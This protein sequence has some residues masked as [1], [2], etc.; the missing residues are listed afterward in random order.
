MWYYRKKDILKR[1]GKD[2]KYIRALDRAIR[3]GRVIREENNWVVRWATRE[4]YE[5]DSIVELNDKVKQMEK[6]L[7]HYKEEVENKGDVDYYIKENE[8]LQNELDDAKGR[9]LR[10]LRNRLHLR[11]IDEEIIDRVFAWDADDYSTDYQ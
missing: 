8:R 9:M 10:F 5:M 1:I 6:L 11:N 2:E 4:D 7:V 3:K